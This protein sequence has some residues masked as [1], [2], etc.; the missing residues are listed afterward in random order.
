ML[1]DDMDVDV[2]EGREHMDALLR[3]LQLAEDYAEQAGENDSLHVRERLVRSLQ[4]A[5]LHSQNFSEVIQR[6][7]CKDV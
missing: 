7:L 6:A 3:S 1:N 4:E 2:E 5:L